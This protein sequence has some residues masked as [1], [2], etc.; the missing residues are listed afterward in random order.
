MTKRFNFSAS[1]WRS[2]AV[3][4]TAALILAGAAAAQPSASTSSTKNMSEG[5]YSLIDLDFFGGYQWFQFGQGTGASI[6]QFKGSG[7]WGE[8]LSEE[9]SNYIG[10]EEG[11]QLGYNAFKFAPLGATSLSQ[12]PAG[13]TEI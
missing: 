10:A 7:V 8:R 5:G 4:M 9:F 12:A 2:T 6:H 13:Q 1:A 11:I 3:A